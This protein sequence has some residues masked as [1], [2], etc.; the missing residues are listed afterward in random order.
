MKRENLNF[1]TD[2]T[3]WLA[4]LVLLATMLSRHVGRILPVNLN[5]SSAGIEASVSDHS[6]DS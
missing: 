2:L 1:R 5:V 6:P 3:F 4:I